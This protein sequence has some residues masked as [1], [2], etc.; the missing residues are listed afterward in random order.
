MYQ[1]GCLLSSYFT[2]LFGLNYAFL[3]EIT[4]FFLLEITYFVMVSYV[5]DVERSAE[6]QAH[7]IWINNAVVWQEMR[8]P[9]AMISILPEQYAAKCCHSRHV[10]GEMGYQQCT[11]DV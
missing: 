5:L 9:Y 6:D 8:E 4:Y 10:W 7:V 1:I 11:A 2:N 3:L